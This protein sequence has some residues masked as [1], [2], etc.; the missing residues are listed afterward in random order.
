MYFFFR[1]IE[2]RFVI[3]WKNWEFNQN[4]PFERLHFNLIL[5]QLSPA[6]CRH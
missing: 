5:F 1:V 2:N 4:I 3:L 6:S